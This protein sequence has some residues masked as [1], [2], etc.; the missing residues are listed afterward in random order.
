MSSKFP[1]ITNWL[2]L[3][4]LVTLGSGLVHFFRSQLTRGIEN[5]IFSQSYL[6]PVA[7]SSPNPTIIPVDQIWSQLKSL[8]DQT[9]TK[10]KL[11]EQL[12]TVRIVNTPTSLSQ[13][14]SGR[15]RWDT[16]GMLFVLPSRHQPRFWMKD[17]KFGLDFVWIDREKIVEITANVPPP[18][19]VPDSAL[20]IYRPAQSVDLVLELPAGAAKQASLRIGDKLQLIP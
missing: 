6:L 13:G 14:L 9:L 20:T 4:L 11:T 5:L 7:G 18:P 8:P 19:P 1:A 3:M 10:I 17:M 2:I 12:Y 15:G 16:D